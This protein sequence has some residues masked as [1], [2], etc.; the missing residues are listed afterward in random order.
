MQGPLEEHD[1]ELGGKVC[2]YCLNKTEFQ[3]FK[4]VMK[5]FTS[6]YIIIKVNKELGLVADWS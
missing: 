5:I 1:T 6:K 4:G 3:N 2:F